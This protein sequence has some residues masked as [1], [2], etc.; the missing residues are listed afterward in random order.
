MSGHNILGSIWLWSLITRE[1]R[2]NFSPRLNAYQSLRLHTSPA[3][4][5]AICETTRCLASVSNKIT[6]RLA[7]VCTSTTS[8]SGA[9]SRIV[10]GLSAVKKHEIKRVLDVITSS[11][12][13]LKPNAWTDTIDCA[14]AL[15]LKSKVPD[16]D[17]EPLEDTFGHVFILTPDAD[18]LPFQ[19]L[20]HEQLTFHIISPAGTPRSDQSPIH[21]NGWKLRSVSGN[22]TQAVSSRKDLDP[23]SVPNQLHILITQARSGKLLGR[24]TELV[25][26]V[27]GGPDC[28]VEG[29]IGKINF[30]ELHPGEVFTVLFKLR[31]GA[32]TEE[33]YSLSHNLTRSSEA[34][35]N[36][37][38][39]LSQLD[40]L[41]GKTD[42]KVLTARLTYRHSLLP[43]G[44]TC[45]ITAECQI[46]RR[47]PDPY[48]KPSLS[49]YNSHQVRDCTVL[50]QKRL[51]YH[52]ATHGS[53]KNALATLYSEFGE[54]THPSAF[55]DY[56]SLLVKELKYQARI[57]QRLEIDAS[58][59]K[60]PMVH[61][62]NSPV[63]KHGQSSID[64]EQYKPQQSIT[65]DIPTEDLFKPKPALAVLS[66][67]ESREQLRTDEA[68]KIWG[69]LRK[70]NRPNNQSVKGRSVS[71]QLEESR[72]EV[73][74]ELAVKNKRSLGSD[75]LRSIFSVG[76][77]T[78]KGLGA[79]WM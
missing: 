40:K 69:D 64:G 62:A 36:T 21:C 74:R 70:M 23:L 44:T 66:V 76:E 47:L 73:I 34:L 1:S 12:E 28:I 63:G 19:S 43:A 14:K 45:S 55:S 32:A 31:V 6:D 37:Q 58:P 7:I 54:K 52:L 77:S 60:F 25:L 30:T 33:G 18:G 71:S 46:K 56:V 35:P 42:A 11:I 50:V 26:E 29:L 65:K 13:K 15:L 67:K 78:G 38:D 24:L 48:Q 16:P 3:T 27:S 59:K 4:L 57:V 8:T 39:I 2:Y 49:K 68:R 41:L 61:A 72:K 79:P 75:T 22:E 10:R 9:D 20:V 5:M 53:P 51:A 17:E